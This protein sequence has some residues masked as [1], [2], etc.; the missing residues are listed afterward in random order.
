ME[1]LSRW[2]IELHP[3]I[4]HRVLAQAEAARGL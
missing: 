3:E 1:N 4:R 2:K